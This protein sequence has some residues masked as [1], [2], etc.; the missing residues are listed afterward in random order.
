MVFKT[1]EVKAGRFCPM[2]VPNIE[3]NVTRIKMVFETQGSGVF[4]NIE[5]V[6][7]AQNCEK[8]W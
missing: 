2:Q 7:V 6:F 5:K 8:G 3:L 1:S 4:F